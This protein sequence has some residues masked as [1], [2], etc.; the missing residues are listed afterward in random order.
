MKTMTFRIYGL[1][2]VLALSVSGATAQDT[3]P[4]PEQATIDAQIQARF[5]ATAAAGE[6]DTDFEA[7]VDAAFFGALT[8]TQQA[9]TATDADLTSATTTATTTPITPPTLEPAALLS[10]ATNMAVIDGGLFQMGTTAGEVAQAVSLCVDEQNGNCTLAMGEDSA[11]QHSVTLNAFEMEI[12]EVTYGQYI[13]FLNTLGAGSHLNGC[14]GQTCL[15]TRS[16]NENATVIVQNG[17][18][19]FPEAVR[20]VAVSNVTWYGAKAYCEALGRRLPTEAEWERAAR[21]SDARIYPWGTDWDPL[22]ARTSI[23]E[24]G[25]I[26]ALPVGSYPFGASPF[27]LLDMAGNVAEWVSDWYSPV[28]YS[29]PNA[30]GLNPTGPDSGEQKVVRGGSWDAKPFFARAVHRQSF[31]PNL[32]GAW[33]GFR[34]AADY[35]LEF[36]PSPVATQVTPTAGPSAT[37]TDTPAPTITPTLSNTVTA[38]PTLSES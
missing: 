35:E 30:S 21:G 24:D 29:S 15:I 31:A 9:L 12:T 25:N 19:V 7:T 4:A 26:G 14:E 22:Y 20:N 18:Y 2:L 32:G 28:Y 1:L 13:A 33:L 17:Q 34:C 8:A 37:P 5:T 38:L 27:G 36:T 16:E 3:T 11:P 10:I 23:P 6:V